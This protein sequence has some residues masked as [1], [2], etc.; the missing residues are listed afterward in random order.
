MVGEHHPWESGHREE[1][2][3]RWTAQQVHHQELLAS[4]ETADHGCCQAW[5]VLSAGIREEVLKEYAV[6]VL[7]SVV[8][9]VLWVRMSKEQEEESLVLAVSYIPPEVTV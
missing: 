6:E 2:G 1:R 8:E 3:N 9:G 5:S 4:G 7:D